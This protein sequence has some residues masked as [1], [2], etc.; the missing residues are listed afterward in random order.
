M[1]P[2]PVISIWAK[3]KCL[4]PCHIFT[5]F[6]KYAIYFHLFCDTT[7]CSYLQLLWKVLSHRLFYSDNDIDFILY[8]ASADLNL[9]SQLL[10]T[11]ASK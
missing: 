6:K 2:L 11:A 9:F 10:H 3:A 8:C 1:Y 7:P 4:H 5:I